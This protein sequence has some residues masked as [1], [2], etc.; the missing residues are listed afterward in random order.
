MEAKKGGVV[1]SRYHPT[2]AEMEEDV[3][4]DAS[5]EDVVRALFPDDPP[6]VESGKGEQVKEEWERWLAAQ[7]GG[8]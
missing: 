6:L 2:R 1:D 3:H 7:E 8:G 5:P 4:I